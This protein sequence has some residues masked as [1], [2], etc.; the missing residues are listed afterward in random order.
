MKRLRLT[1][2]TLTLGKVDDVMEKKKDSIWF[3]REDLIKALEENPESVY[4]VAPGNL[5]ETMVYHD[6]TYEILR[7]ENPKRPKKVKVKKA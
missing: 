3:T 5:R 7:D 4:I 1:L 6:G 2:E